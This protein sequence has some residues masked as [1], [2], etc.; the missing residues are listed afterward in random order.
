MLRRAWKPLSRSRIL[1]ALSL[2]MFPVGSSGPAG[3][4]A[5]GEAAGDGHPL[6]LTGESSLGY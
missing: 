4:P 1:A 2:S 6:A 3:S 5:V